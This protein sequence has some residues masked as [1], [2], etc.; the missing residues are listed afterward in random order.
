[1][2]ATAVEKRVNTFTSSITATPD[3][4]ARVAPRLVIGL[5]G[6]PFAAKAAA[7]FRGFGW[8]VILT[9]TGEEARRLAIRNR[10]KALVIGVDEGGLLHAAKLLTA[11]PRRTKAVLTAPVA[12]GA[13]KRASRYLGAAFVAEDDGVGALVRVVVGSACV[14]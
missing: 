2:S 4:N 13:L 5:N 10:A 3:T 14:G 1:M 6:S 11:L 7:E 8:E 9:G 12:D